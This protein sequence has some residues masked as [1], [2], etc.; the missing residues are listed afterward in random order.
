MP[1]DAQQRRDTSFARLMWVLTIAYALWNGFWYV[2]RF[3][4]L[5]KGRRKDV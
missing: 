1:N 3:G 4:W 5:R 2:V